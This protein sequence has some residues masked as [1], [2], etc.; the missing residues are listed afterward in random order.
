MFRRKHLYQF[1]TT[2]VAL[3]HF[4]EDLIVLFEIVFEIDMTFGLRISADSLLYIKIIHERLWHFQSCIDHRSWVRIKQLGLNLVIMYMYRAWN[5]KDLF[6][7]ANLHAAILVFLNFTVLQE[8]YGQFWL[9]DDWDIL[10]L[11]WTLNLLLRI[12]HV[13]HRRK[14]F[15]LLMIIWQT[16]WAVL[17]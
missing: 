2:L 12:W 17:V 4:I 6:K 7:S 14:L 9:F 1:V 15:L 10:H 5:L 8:R 16:F 3:D 13:Q 11:D